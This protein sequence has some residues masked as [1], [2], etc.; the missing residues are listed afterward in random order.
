MFSL[1]TGWRDKARPLKRITYD[2]DAAYAADWF[3]DAL[4]DSAVG[5][6]LGGLGGAVDAV[7]DSGAGQQ[8]STREKRRMS[9]EDLKRFLQGISEK[10]VEFSVNGNVLEAK[11][12]S[13]GIRNWGIKNSAS[14]DGAGRG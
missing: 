11:L 1:Y 5:A 10:P 13:T 4:Y 7:T 9:L 2:P 14:L 12:Y 8:K 3:A 6:A